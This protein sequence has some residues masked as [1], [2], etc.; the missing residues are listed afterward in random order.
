MLGLLSTNAPGWFRFD[1]SGERLALYTTE[2]DTNVFIL[3][4]RTGENLKTLQH[5][6]PVMSIAWHPDGVLLATGCEDKTIHVWD[7]RSG[8]QIQQWRTE[9]SV[10]L[11]FNHGGNVLASSGWD[12]YTRL[13]ELERATQL[14]SI[15]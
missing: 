7:S 3:D 13:W 6:A 5:G 10:S 4:V 2:A 9:S 14:I 15:Y 8:N 1:G 12:G 11:G